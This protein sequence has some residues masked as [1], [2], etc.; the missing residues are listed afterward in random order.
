MIEIQDLMISP[1]GSK[2][3]LEDYSITQIPGLQKAQIQ[4]FANWDDT[5]IGGVPGTKRIT[6]ERV[7][8][9]SYTHIRFRWSG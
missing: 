5:L 1:L 3:N 7:P 9:D 8:S 4:D 6:L 2:I